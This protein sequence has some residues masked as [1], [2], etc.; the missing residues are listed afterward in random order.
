MLIGKVD[1]YVRATSTRDDHGAA[2]PGGWRTTASNTWSFRLILYDGVQDG[3]VT[4]L[5]NMKEPILLDLKI[6]L[7]AV[8][9]WKHSGKQPDLATAALSQA[10]GDDDITFRAK[11][12]RLLPSRATLLMR[13]TV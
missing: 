11:T 2:F 1:R 5:K 7:G 6:I 12:K 9:A 3:S 10:G 8:I 4:A 13:Q